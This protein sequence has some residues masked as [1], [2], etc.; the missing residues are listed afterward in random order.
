ML[1]PEHRRN[2]I[3]NSINNAANYLEDKQMADGSWY[4]SWGICFIFGTWFAIRG[5][6][7]AGRYYNNCEAVRRGVDFLLKIQRDDGG[8]A[9][10]YTSCPNKVKKKKNFPF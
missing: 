2:E 3:D 10:S 6:E 1:H 8:W 7:S 9:E 5:L 4:G